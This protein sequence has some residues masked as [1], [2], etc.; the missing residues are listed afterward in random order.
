MRELQPVEIHRAV[1]SQSYKFYDNFTQM[2]RDELSDLKR[3]KTQEFNFPN[4]AP[5]LKFLRP[6][7]VNT[8]VKPYFILPAWISDPVAD[9]L[10]ALKLSINA[11]TRK[12][13]GTNLSLAEGVMVLGPYLEMRMYKASL[14]NGEIIEGEAASAEVFADS[15]QGAKKLI[16]ANI[17]SKAAFDAIEQRGVEVI[18][19][20]LVPIFAQEAKDAGIINENTVV[21]ASDFG[22]LQMCLEFAEL[23]GLDVEK[24]IVVLDKGARDQDGETEG[25]ELMYGEENL[26]ENSVVIMLDDI[27]DTGGSVDDAEEFVVKK[28]VKL[29]YQFFTH[30]VFSYPADD[31]VLERFKRGKVKGMWVS[32]SLPQAKYQLNA[33]ERIHTIEIARL[34]SWI[35]VA[36]VDWSKE[37]LMETPSLGDYI[38]EPKNKNLVWLEF[39]ERVNCSP[40]SLC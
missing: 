5:F 4:Q 11:L 12:N 33:D 40:D 25:L 7:G 1:P 36:S 35:I 24:Q 38:M 6:E 31:N 23:C 28:G 21:V 3:W 15:L 18:N 27:H 29:I 26:N 34:L 19:V 8:D 32:D 37:E 39:C 20:T 9:S 22:S 14:K 16:T 17:H 10:L 30:G 13:E 2:I